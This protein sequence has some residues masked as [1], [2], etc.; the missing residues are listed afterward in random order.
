MPAPL[1]RTLARS[2]LV[3]AATAFA[4]P[5]PAQDIGSTI[6]LPDV[7]FVLPVLSTY[8]FPAD[9]RPGDV[10]TQRANN[11]RDSATYVPG[12]NS[13]T[14]RGFRRIGFMP[15]SG[16]G[17]CHPDAVPPDPHCDG[18]AIL[19][20]PLY[21]G[22]AVVRGQRQPA[23][24]FASANN[25]VYA[26]SARIPFNLL[27][28][29]RLGPPFDGDPNSPTADPGRNCD[30]GKVGIESTPVIDLAHSQI[31]VSSMTADARHHISGPRIER[32]PRDP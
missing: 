3:A 29:T 12:L 30:S 10:L 32:R 22:S 6:T 13:N 1:L 7:P 17:D 14:V 27:W 2:A 9:P 16:D 5:T 23:V 20:Q 18:G 4:P 24:F 21:G 28:S 8:V 15:A 25:F 26:Y 31:L 19:T 11:N